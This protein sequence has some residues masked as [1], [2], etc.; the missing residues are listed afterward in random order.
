M[1]VH[2][3]VHLNSIQQ[4]GTE[5]LVLG[6]MVGKHWGQEHTRVPHQATQ[7]LLCAGSYEENDQGVVTEG[8]GE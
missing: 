8:N 5:H 3:W 6:Q 4:L 2:L 7:P 1:T